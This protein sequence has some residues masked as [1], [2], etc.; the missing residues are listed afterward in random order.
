MILNLRHP[1]LSLQTVT[2]LDGVGWGPLSFLK[3]LLS[4]ARWRN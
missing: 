1:S 4:W 3:Q 2:D